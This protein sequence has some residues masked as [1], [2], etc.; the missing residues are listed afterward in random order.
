MSA[1]G[2]VRK[3]LSS[4]TAAQLQLYQMSVSSFGLSCQLSITSLM[5]SWSQWYTHPGFEWTV[6]ISST[7]GLAGFQLESTGEWLT[8]SLLERVKSQEQPVAIKFTPMRYRVLCFLT[9]LCLMCCTTLLSPAPHC[10]PSTTKWCEHYNEVIM[11]LLL[12][13]WPML[14]GSKRHLRKIN[15]NCTQRSAIRIKPILKENTVHPAL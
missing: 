5:T 7:S 4:K 6:E 10:K 12:H 1:D 2:S 8:W 11:K 14:P 3:Q 13:P 9:R 15:E